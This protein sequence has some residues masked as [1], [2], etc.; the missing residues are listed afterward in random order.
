[1]KSEENELGFFFGV[2][3]RVDLFWP[4]ACGSCDLW[5]GAWEWDGLD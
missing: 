5:L 1:M 2:G 4:V 3:H